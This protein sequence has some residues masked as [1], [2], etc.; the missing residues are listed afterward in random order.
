MKA[1]GYSFPAG[2][3]TPEVARL[4]YE[5]LILELRRSIQ[6]VETGEFQAHMQVELVNDGP[7]TMLLDSRRRF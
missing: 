2:M 4:L 6:H 7:V 3:L 5:E 1:K